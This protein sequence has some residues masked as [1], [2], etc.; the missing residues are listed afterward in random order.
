MRALLRK[1]YEVYDFVANW[2]PFLTSDLVTLP[3]GHYTPLET[4]MKKKSD[5]NYSATSRRFDPPE[6]PYETEISSLDLSTNGNK[7]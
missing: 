1:S 4:L 6:K 2:P 7:F 3:K 5:S